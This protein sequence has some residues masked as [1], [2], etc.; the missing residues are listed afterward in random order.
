MP[1]VRGHFLASLFV[2]RAVALVDPD[3]LPWVSRKGEE[4]F[5][6]GPGPEPQAMSHLREYWVPR[7]R[8]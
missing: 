1:W 7:V 3:Q 6:H 5:S 2:V 4:I 8:R